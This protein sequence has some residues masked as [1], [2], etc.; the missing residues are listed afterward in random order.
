M[1]ANPQPRA[2]TSRKTSLV[3]P[4]SGYYGNAMPTRRLDSDNE[5]GCVSLANDFE[6]LQEIY[7]CHP[8]QSLSSSSASSRNSVHVAVDQQQFYQPN[9]IHQ[10]EELSQV[11]K[12]AVVTGTIP[13]P[14]GLRP[15]S[16]LRA[17]QAR[18]G[19]PRPSG[20][21]RR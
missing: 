16:N 19:L 11:T 9:S 3:R 6:S 21:V 5:S 8:L 2:P 18:S 12:K 14:S 13:K 10:A 4:S 20:I 15:P 17:P 1:F 7:L